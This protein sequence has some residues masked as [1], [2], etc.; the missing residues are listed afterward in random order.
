MMHDE[1][2]TDPADQLAVIDSAPDLSRSASVGERVTG[3]I[4]LVAL[5]GGLVVSLESD[6]PPVAGA[7]VFVAAT[8][9]LLTWNGHH[10]GA[11]RRRPHT[12]VEMAVRF[13]GVVFLCMP[14]A[15][16]IFDEGSDSL[17]GH[18]ISAALP[19]AAAAVY[20]LLRWRR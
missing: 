12:K 6:L 18:L 16:L 14:G 1:P 10:D 2:R 13:C 15:E 19:T 17:T 7:A 5:Y 4:T 3:V 11:A 8:M 20:F 9:L